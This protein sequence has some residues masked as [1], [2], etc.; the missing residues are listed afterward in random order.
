MLDKIKRAS[1]H[2]VY[3]VFTNII[4]GI[5][6]YLVFKLLVGF[7][8]LYAYLGCIALIIIGLLLDNLMIKELTSEKTIAKINS[9]TEKDKKSNISLI[10]LVFDC[11]VSFKTILFIFY[12]F[13]IIAS[14]IINIAPSLVG[15]NLTNFVTA[16]SYGIV[17]LIAIDRMVGHFAKDKAEM[18]KNTEVFMQKVT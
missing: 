17:L 8:L 3:I 7:S 14:Q 4:F 6:Y 13:I 1:K 5:L 10:L 12:L 11:F 16:N 2:I 15:E 9:L 18:K